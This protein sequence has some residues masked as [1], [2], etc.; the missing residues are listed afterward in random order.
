MK[1]TI[2]SRFLIA[3][4]FTVVVGA[5][6]AAL[7]L[8]GQDMSSDM[9]ELVKFVLGA[10]VGAATIAMARLA[11]PESHLQQDI[12]ALKLEILN[13]RAAREADK[14]AADARDAEQRRV[15]AD[16]LDRLGAHDAPQLLTDQRERKHNEPL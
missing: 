4:F 7:L 14:A 16:L 2:F 10:F 8:Y 11:N 6:F 5:I 15:I 13:E 9:I 3:A 1:S 12:D